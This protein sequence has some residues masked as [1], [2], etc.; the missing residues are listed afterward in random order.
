[1]K[2]EELKKEVPKPQLNHDQLEE[3]LDRLWNEIEKLKVNLPTIS[4]NIS[5]ECQGCGS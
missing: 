3:K 5:D 1:M 2:N 4:I